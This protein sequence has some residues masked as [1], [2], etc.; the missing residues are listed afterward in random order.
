VSHEELPSES[1][2]PHHGR[3][4]YLHLL[5][6]GLLVI[7]CTLAYFF[8]ARQPSSYSGPLLVLDHVYS[9]ALVLVLLGICAG[10]GRRVF[11]LTGLVLDRSLDEMAFSTATGATLIAVS[12][13]LC[14]LVGLLWLPVILAV[15]IAWSL[16][17]RKE[18][19]GLPQLLARSAGQ[20]RPVEA[21]ST[22]P[23]IGMAVLAIVAAVVIV[24]AL[25]PPSDWDSLMYHL[26]VPRHFLQE[27]RVYL[28]HDNLHAAY[29]GLVHMLYVPLIALGSS[30]GPAVLN[31]FFALLLGLTVFSLAAR[32]FGVTSA[33]I[34]LITLWA[35]TGILMVAITPRIDV[36]LALFLILAQYALLIALLEPTRRS[37]FLLAA[38]LLG[39]AVG[40]KYSALAYSL[41]LAP[42]VLWVAWES[43]DNLRETPK[44]LVLFASLFVVAAIPWLA[45]NIVLFGAPLYP[46]FAERILPPWLASLYGTRA[47]PAGVDLTALRAVSGARMPFNLVDLFL[48]PGR[49]TVEQ[50]G[51]HYHMNFLYVLLP[52]SVFFFRHKV[53]AWLLLP[54]LTYLF[55]ILV[56][57]PATNLRYLIP[58]FAPL[59]VAVSYIAVRTSNRFFSASAAS[60]LVGSMAVL[61][62]FPSAKAMRTWLL[63]S[64]VLGSLTGAT[65]T[66]EYLATG[67]SLHYQV[68]Q[69]AN[70]LV[71]ADGK[72]LL[73]YEARGFYFEPEVIQDNAITN[74][75]LLEP[76]MRN[77]ESCLESTGVTHVL[78]NDLA[79]RYYVRRG[80]NPE[81][82]RLDSLPE[83]ARRCLTVIH[84]GQGFTL[85]RLNR[86]PRVE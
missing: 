81:L 24:Q 28:P 26:Q 57:F 84:R 22:L 23:L 45:K 37:T 17:A 66:Q 38:F 75:T 12:I 36:T 56:P 44:H 13:L 61:S 4:N 64:D 55:I 34:A 2:H 48:A 69:A 53:F 79:V 30:T 77:S 83:F 16:F 35:T 49:L 74:W 62:L 80:M 6:I 21:S 85:L 33:S 63:K 59:T 19:T 42:L 39:S 1:V 52:L 40:V 54:A 41:A 15:L 86:D 25:A 50:E 46:F 20:L 71:P 11:S 3:R 51:M 9:T 47:I 32:F 10:V 5:L 27:G 58:A 43:T 73:F 67:Y 60:L 72:L 8:V 70:N 82:L 68:L 18:I 7:A 76:L 29:V 31:A 14:G 78:V 65:S